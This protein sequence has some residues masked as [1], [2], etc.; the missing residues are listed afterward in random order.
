MHEGFTHHGVFLREPI[1]HL[2]KESQSSKK[3]TKNSDRLGRRALLFRI[4]YLPST[5]FESRPSQPLVGP[6]NSWRFLHDL[7]FSGYTICT[8]YWYRMYNTYKTQMGISFRL[9]IT[10]VLLKVLLR[11]EP[12]YEMLVFLK[13]SGGLSLLVTYFFRESLIIQHVVQYCLLIELW[14]NVI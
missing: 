5:C 8:E 13:Y 9:R 4:Q 3:T 12:N 10:W 2:C 6:V 14:W 1:T 11:E 7:W